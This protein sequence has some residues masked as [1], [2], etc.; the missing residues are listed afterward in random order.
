MVF[1]WRQEVPGPGTLCFLGINK[2]Q[3]RRMLGRGGEG[4]GKAGG[5]SQVTLALK[6]STFVGSCQHYTPV[7]AKND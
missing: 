7:K 3:D 6:S 5:H 4:G 2:T 1:S